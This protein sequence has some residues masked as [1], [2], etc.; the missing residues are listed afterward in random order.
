MIKC[1]KC[2][3]EIVKKGGVFFCYNCKGY[4]MSYE[5][6][7]FNSLINSYDK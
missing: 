2:S 4:K 5:T 6:Y 1:N 3:S 7:K